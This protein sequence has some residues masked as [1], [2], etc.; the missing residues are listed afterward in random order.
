MARLAQTSGF[1]GVIIQSD[2]QFYDGR[3]VGFDSSIS[4]PYLVVSSKVLRFLVANASFISEI[5]LPEITSKDAR[6]LKAICSAYIAWRVIGGILYGSQVF[7][8]GY[9]LWME[10]VFL[11]KTRKILWQSV[12]LKVLAFIAALFSFLWVSVDPFGFLGLI[13]P[14]AM[15]IGVVAGCFFCMFM[16]LLQI[17]I[18]AV[19]GLG[20]MNCRLVSMVVYS[21]STFMVI[22][23]L[24]QGILWFNH[25]L[26]I[27][28]M[29]VMALILALC[30]F[31]FIFTGK[32]MI[33]I[34]QN[35]N[36]MADDQKRLSKKI[37]SF[38]IF[39]LSMNSVTVIVY[40]ANVLGK[41]ASLMVVHITCG[42]IILCTFV[43]LFLPV[44]LKHQPWLNVE[45]DPASESSPRSQD[46]LPVAII[47]ELI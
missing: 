18:L 16:F 36:N 30:G 14:S 11:F 33:T 15:Y 10:K 25:P 26:R 42:I 20:E 40:L 24:F 34:L 21:L 38:V 4:I 27:A 5:E 17:W 32:R 7:M 3:I 44:V 43:I 2:E 41:V 1:T 19:G 45:S 46:D 47:A 22:L 13:F 9:F 23:S 28:A 31:G 8:I 35:G 6:H 37:A 39:Y 12:S 29:F